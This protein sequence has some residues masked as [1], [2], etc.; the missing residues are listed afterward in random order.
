MNASLNRLIESNL[1]D[2][3]VITK[4]WLIH[5]YTLSNQASSFPHSLQIQDADS[6]TTKV[7]KKMQYNIYCA[8]STTPIM[9][10]QDICDKFE[11]DE[12]A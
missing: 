3:P 5:D 4:K 1:I 12:L 8:L 2:S 9:K 11:N 10:L 6:T 7:R